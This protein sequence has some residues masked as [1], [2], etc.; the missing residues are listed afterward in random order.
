MGLA[1]LVAGVAGVSV[2]FL[3]AMTDGRR[4]A[5]SGPERC[6]ELQAAGRVYVARRVPAGAV[7]A[8]PPLLGSA[9]LVCGGDRVPDAVVARVVGLAPELALVRPGEG[10][11]VYVAEDRCRGAVS[12][13]D[14][15]ECL[16]KERSAP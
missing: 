5:I 15:V 8:G 12:G 7:A 11:L 16:H 2:A 13:A 9:V 3:E 10:G 14:L 6:S 4:A 1:V